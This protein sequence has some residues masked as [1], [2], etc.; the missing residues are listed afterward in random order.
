MTPGRRSPRTAAAP[1]LGLALAAAAPAFA[2]AELP[3]W[4]GACLS[5]HGERARYHG[6]LLAAGWSEIPAAGRAEAMLTL[7]DAFLGSNT[8]AIDWQDPGVRADA[9]E[10]WGDFTRDAPLFAQAG[11]VLHLASYRSDGPLMA[12]ECWV[13]LPGPDLTEPHLAAGRAD[14]RLESFG[15]FVML[16]LEWDHSRTQAITLR[17]LRL[18]PPEALAPPLAAMDALLIVSAFQPSE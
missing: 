15:G 10:A 13:A 12:V 4:L 3:T 18:D 11:A 1:L 14:G 17:A 2:E 5:D 16:S 7:A 9:L 6:E 8:Y